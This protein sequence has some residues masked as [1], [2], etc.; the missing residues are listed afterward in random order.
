MNANTTQDIIIYRTDDGKTQIEVNLRDETV[1]ITQKYM[2]ELFGTERSVVTKHISNVLET[3]ELQRNSVC[4]KF[5]HTAADGKTYQTQ[6]YNLDMIIS[7]GYRVNSKRGTQFR[8]WATNVLKQHLIEG[9]TLNEKRLRAQQE[10]YQ[11][12]L[13]AVRLLGQIAEHRELSSSQAADLIRVVRDYAYGL[14]LI[15]AYDHKRLEVAGVSRQKARPISHADARRAIEQLRMQYQASDL[16]GREKDKSFQGSLVSIFQTFGKRQLYPSIEEKAANLLY[17]LVKNHP[18]VDGNK[19]I[20]AFMFLWFL[21][22]NRALYRKDGS[23]RIADNALVAITLMVAE[24]RPTD[25]DL[26]VKVIINL[27]NQKN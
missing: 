24:S 20:A 26:I 25:K 15:D 13:N 5:A 9:Y 7:V 12:L 10:K 1:W 4:A 19:R 27:I 23:K 22:I 3:K 8:I 18:F 17:F 21:D 14:D 2:A 16:F 11:E 6:F